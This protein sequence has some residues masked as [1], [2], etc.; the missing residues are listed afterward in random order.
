MRVEG[1]VVV[2]C[3]EGSPGGELRNAP[4]VGL[5]VVSLLGL[6]LLDGCPGVVA[7]GV[8]VEA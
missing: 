6:G 7:E 1:Q 2:L 3:L 4:F 5:L 8:W